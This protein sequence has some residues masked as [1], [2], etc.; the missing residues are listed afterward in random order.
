MDLDRYEVRRDGATDRADAGRVPPAPDLLE[1]DGRVLTRD[2]LLDAVYGRDQ[3]EVM[4]RTIDVHIGR[5]RDKLGDDAE[6][7]R[8]VATVRGI[9]YRAAPS[10]MGHGIALR[11]ALAAFLSAAVGI[12]DPGRRRGRRRRGDLPG[13][14]GRSGRL[15][16]SRPGDVRPVGHHRRLRRRR[17]GTRASVV[18]A[19][20][21]GPDAGTAAGGR[22]A[23]R[24]ARS[25]TATTP[26]GSRAT[27]RRRSPRSP[28]RSTRW[29]PAWSA[30][31]R[32]G[33]TSSPTPPTNC[34]RR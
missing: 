21:P 20:A 9:G 29:P 16:R 27:V 22:R 12:V 3:S 5:L 28:T 24:R 19:L 7:P 11:I 4:D 2:Q 18:L 30:R 32:C 8:Y 14:D 13:P 25:R 31:R 33:A 23:R 10:L 1:A 26:P 15:G 34:G 17:R 6:A